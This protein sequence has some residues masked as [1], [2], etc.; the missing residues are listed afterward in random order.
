MSVV[1]ALIFVLGFDLTIEAVWD[2]RHRVNRMEY[3]TI[4]VIIIGMTVFDFVIGLFIGIILACVFFVVQS[5]RRRPIRTVF[6]GATAKSTVRR[7]AAQRAFIQMVG[8]QTYV[9]K[10]QGFLFFGT[11]AVVEDEI[12][13]LLDLAMWE[14]N[15][16]R[17]LIIDF[18]LVGGLDFSSAEAFVRIQ[19]LLAAKD[20]LLILCGA[21]PHGLVGTALRAVD[22]WADEDGSQVEVFRTLNDALEW[23]EN[24]YLTVF[25]D[26]KARQRPSLQ[27][28]EARGIDLP[29]MAKVPFSLAESFQNS[30]RR[31]LLARAGDENLHSGFV[32][33]GS[34]LAPPAQSPKSPPAAE[35]HHEAPRPFGQPLQILLQT[36]GPYTDAGTEFFQG[37]APYFAQVVVETGHVLW[38]QGSA[39]DGLYLIESGSLRATYAFDEHAEAIHE[40]MVAGTVAGD[41]SALSD[42][43][44]NATVVAERDCVLWKLT[45]EALEKMQKERPEDASRLTKVVLKGAVEEVDVLS[46]HLIAVL[47]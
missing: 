42:T 25:Y 22:L 30:P 32:T 29:K 10:L 9:M 44:R 20:V 45:P 19:R 36:L 24:A 27:A 34:T 21:E 31:T 26:N 12:R 5:S 37:V 11:I 13:K 43:P 8:S 1:A 40:T 46:A 17:F 18:A 33:Y 3:I 47:S 23:T 28:T 16:I 15:P 7:P 41:L 14:N 2:T 4:W 39:S 6:S 35:E 38:R